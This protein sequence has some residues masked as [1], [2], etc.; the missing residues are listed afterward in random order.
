[1]NPGIAA[2]G[3]FV[4]KRLEADFQGMGLAQVEFRV[5]PSGDVTCV[6]G[7]HEFL[8]PFDDA[9]SACAYA[10]YMLQDDVIDRLG[11]PWPELLDPG[12]KF[13]GVLV[14]PADAGGSGIAHWA[15]R[16]DPFC[17]VGHLHQAVQAAGW[18]IK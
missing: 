4:R 2:M 9:E 6:C 3:D 15:L 14:A 8:L 17:A 16:N 7:G 1:M 13:I 11:R 18:L 12:G 10:A 5:E